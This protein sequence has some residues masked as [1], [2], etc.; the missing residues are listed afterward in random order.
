[1]WYHL[2]WALITQIHVS[3]GKIVKIYCVDNYNRTEKTMGG[4]HKR[5]RPNILKLYFRIFWGKKVIR[6]QFKTMI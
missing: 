5:L 4:I 1:M 6:R 2:D 3:C